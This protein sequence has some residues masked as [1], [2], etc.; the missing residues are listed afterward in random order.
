MIAVLDEHKLVGL[1]SSAK[2][3]I[4]SSG[5]IINA[6]ARERANFLQPYAVDQTRS[7][8]EV[9]LES[10]RTLINRVGEPVCVMFRKEHA[11]S[12]FDNRFLQLGDIDYWLRIL[13]HCQYYFL[14]E[15][16]CDFRKHEDSTTRHHTKSLAKQLDWFLLAG[17]FVHYLKELPETEAQFCQRLS[18]RLVNQLS[19]LFSSVYAGDKV[20]HECPPYDNLLTHMASLRRQGCSTPQH[21]QILSF[22]LVREAVRLSNE[23]SFKQIALDELKNTVN[24][25]EQQLSE[26]DVELRESRRVLDAMGS[27]LSW[28]VT[29]PL[30]SAKKLFD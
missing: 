18:S 25:Q 6:D 15:P 19:S 7:G 9:I 21:F 20:F 28:K 13:E 27:S 1:V 10:L 26:R 22:L 12:G 11:G 16:L 23:L 30:R 8:K 2:H 4:D 3:W 17:K 5:K 24:E 29:A 14:S